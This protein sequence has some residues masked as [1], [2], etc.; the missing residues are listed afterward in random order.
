MKA[1]GKNLRDTMSTQLASHLSLR[2][3]DAAAAD[4]VSG[5]DAALGVDAARGRPLATPSVLP[6]TAVPPADDDDEEDDVSLSV[7]R[8]VDDDAR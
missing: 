5:T 1:V 4:A 6:P 2:A 8:N 3:A 7:V